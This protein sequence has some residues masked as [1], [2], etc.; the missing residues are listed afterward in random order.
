MG[1]GTDNLFIPG[2]FLCGKTENILPLV[3][4]ENAGA[5]MEAVFFI[6]LLNVNLYRVVGPHLRVDNFSRIVK[7]QKRIH[8]RQISSHRVYFYYT[9][10]F[11]KGK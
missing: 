8:H 9:T 10:K 5:I 11:K 2:H 7:G 6:G 3:A 4:G 1:S